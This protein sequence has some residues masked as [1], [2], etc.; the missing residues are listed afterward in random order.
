MMAMRRL[1]FVFALL[2][3]LAC[4]TEAKNPGGKGETKKA[5]RAPMSDSIHVPYSDVQ[6]CH[7]QLK[8]KSPWL[9]QWFNEKLVPAANTHDALLVRLDAVLKSKDEAWELFLTEHGGNPRV[10]QGP[11]E[12][13][14]GDL[15]LALCDRAIQNASASPAPAAEKRQ[16]LLAISDAAQKKLGWTNHASFIKQEVEVAL[17]ELK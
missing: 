6:V 10:S 9:W 2:S 3:A 7:D 5:S 1:F 17:Q 11:W 14:V 15:A 13:A 16:Q 8:S 12:C 4:R